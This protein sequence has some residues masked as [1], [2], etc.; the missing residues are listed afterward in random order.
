MN[1]LFHARTTLS[2]ASE[3]RITGL[4]TVVG[5]ILFDATGVRLPSLPMVAEGVSL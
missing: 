3:A 1:Y 4:A 2:F 5:N